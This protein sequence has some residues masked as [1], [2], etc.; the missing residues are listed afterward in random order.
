MTFIPTL[1]SLTRLLGSALLIAVIAAACGSDD[2]GRIDVSEAQ[3]RTTPN[4]LGAGYLTI[5]NT[6]D[7][8]VTLRA[9]SSPEVERIE[10]HESEMQDGVIKMTPRPEGFTVDPGAQV[11]LEPGGKHL[12]LFSPEPSGDELQITLDFGTE[13]I[14]VAAEFDAEASAAHDDMG[15]MDDM[16]SGEMDDGDMDEMNDATTSG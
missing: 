2:S 7:D 12:M 14:V 10:L 1:R 9:A 8:P 15:G 4:G 16:D 5:S 11:V 3:F 13:T 6:T